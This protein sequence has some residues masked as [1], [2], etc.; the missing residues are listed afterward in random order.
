MVGGAVLG[1]LVNATELEQLVV[2]LC[3]CGQ[4]VFMRDVVRT[5]VFPRCC[6]SFDCES[7]RLTASEHEKV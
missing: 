3:C 2:V 4:I 1:L 7:F 6:C 5:N